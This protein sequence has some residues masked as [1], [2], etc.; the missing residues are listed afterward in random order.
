MLFTEE[1]N[2]SN[3]KDDSFQKFINDKLIK[4][5]SSINSKQSLKNEK[6]VSTISTITHRQKMKSSTNLS[7][8]M[9]SNNKNNDT[10]NTINDYIDEKASKRLSKGP[11]SVKN[12]GS[13]NIKKGKNKKDILDLCKEYLIKRSITKKTIATSSKYF[14]IDNSTKNKRN[15]NIPLGRNIDTM[16][17]E[18]SNTNINNKI[19]PLHRRHK[20]SS[21]MAVFR[22]KN[23][24]NHLMDYKN[25]KFVIYNAY[26][27]LFNFTR[28]N[29]NFKFPN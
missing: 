19:V 14:Q 3:F 7:N 12:Y 22:N 26:F 17:I 9:N 13:P 11:I 2:Y 18:S 20:S 8:L 27:S 28:K 5:F 1:Q 4:K 15:L 25:C 29:Y 24:Q 21:S 16:T 6:T 10:I 23:N